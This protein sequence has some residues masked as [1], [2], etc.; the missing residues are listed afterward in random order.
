MLTPRGGGHV[1]DYVRR[2]GGRAARVARAPPSG[3][4]GDAVSAPPRHARHARRRGQPW[5]CKLPPPPTSFRRRRLR[6]E[7]S[8]P[9]QRL[10]GGSEGR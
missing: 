6:L 10:Q 1:R 3:R 5:A 7:H 4:S 9:E 8:A 2:R